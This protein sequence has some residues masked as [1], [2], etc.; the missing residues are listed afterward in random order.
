MNRTRTITYLACLGVFAPISTDIYLSSMPI[1]SHQL[2][3]SHAQ[4]QLT[5]SLFFISF[6]FMQLIWGPLSDRYGRKP[7]VL[8]GLL[9]FI[10]F[11]S[12]SALSQS[13]DQ[14]IVSRFFQ[15][16]GAC[17]GAVMTLAMTKDL[18]PD[19]EELK[20]VLRIT[21]SMVFIAPMV[22]P[23]IGSNLLHWFDWQANFV[24]LAIYG[25]L[26]LIAALF[27]KESFPAEKRS[28]PSLGTLL[29]SY[30]EQIKHPPFILMTLA[31]ATNFCV[32]FSFI[33]GS[34]LI[35]ITLYGVAKQNFGYLFAI[36]ASGLIVATLLSSKMNK[37]GYSEKVILTTG[38]IIGA[39]G[40]IAM[41]IA[42]SLWP[43][44]LWSVAVPCYFATFGTGML[45]GELNGLALHHT[46]KHAGISA[47]LVGTGRYGVAG[48]ASILIGII[49]THSAIPL[50]WTMLGF[51]AL[52][53]LFTF[54]FF[55]LNHT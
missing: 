2:H 27:V 45:F 26:L 8:L 16:I 49:L 38:L 39:C 52:T 5:L 29:H 47:A 23:I 37:R 43:Q 11:S 32:M 48:F 19:K 21:L 54:I 7:M 33:A 20:Q 24:L 22:G 55:R 53:A 51:I 35:Y 17:S 46:V 25:S 14:L 4:V 34:P 12:L 28:P 6:A 50:A 36:N 1:I 31:A 10:V 9:I 30:L 15:A 3:A 18:F 40:A 41:I 13:I 42:L 44:T